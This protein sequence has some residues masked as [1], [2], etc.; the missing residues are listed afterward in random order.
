[1][2]VLK[3]VG[4]HF[5]ESMTGYL[6]KGQSDPVKG[7]N[8]GAIRTNRISFDVRIAIQDLSRFLKVI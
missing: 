1:M 6:G 4:L 7:Q 5:E 3:G 2:S 8:S